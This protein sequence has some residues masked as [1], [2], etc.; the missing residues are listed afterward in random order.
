M[1]L[2]DHP[3]KFGPGLTK[4]HGPQVQSLVTS[5]CSGSKLAH[6]G[7]VLPPGD[8]RDYL[9]KLERLQVQVYDELSRG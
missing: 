9:Q 3:S 5:Y 7:R 2:L 6:L 4:V 1:E 8:V